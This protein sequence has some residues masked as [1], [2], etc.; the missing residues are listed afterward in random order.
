MVIMFKWSREDGS[1]VLYRILGNNDLIKLN[2]NRPVPETFRVSPLYKGMVP[3][4][5]T[6]C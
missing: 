2:A 5:R 6:R 4:A 3:Y 1:T